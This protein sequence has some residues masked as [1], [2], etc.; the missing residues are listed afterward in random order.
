MKL[1]S[2][3]DGLSVKVFRTYNA[4][5]NMDRL[6]GEVLQRRPFPSR[7]EDPLQ[8]KTEYDVANKEVSYLA[9][10]SRGSR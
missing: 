6:L 5:V 1:K 7:D 3:M 2:L 4:S 10:G 8:R 9:S